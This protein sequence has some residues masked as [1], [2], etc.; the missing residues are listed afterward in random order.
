M[1]LYLIVLVAIAVFTV[2]AI[3]VT[4]TKCE[5]PSYRIGS[6]RLAGC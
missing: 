5:S 3:A 1:K 4:P 2:A 6:F